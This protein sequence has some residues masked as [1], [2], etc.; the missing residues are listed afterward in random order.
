MARITD[1][2]AQ[3]EAEIAALPLASGEAHSH[4]QGAFWRFKASFNSIEPIR[5]GRAVIL[6]GGLQRYVEVSNDNIV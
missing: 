4:L 5:E 6:V 2:L 3:L 1:L